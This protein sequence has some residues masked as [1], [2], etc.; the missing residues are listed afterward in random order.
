MVEERTRAELR[1]WLSKR[2]PQ[3]WKWQLRPAT[4]T[5]GAGVD[6]VLRVTSPAG[7][8]SRFYVETK[9]LAFPAEVASR[10]STVPRR[11]L[12]FVAPRISPRS[13]QILEEAGVDWI[14]SE[15]GDARIVTEDI[16]IERTTEGASGRWRPEDERR[17]WVADVFSGA[18]V[19]IVR[20]LLIEPERSWKLADMAE[21]VGVTAAFVSRVFTTLERDAYLQKERAA[22]RLRDRDALLEAW[23][24]AP[25]PPEQRF[26]RA[27]VH[28]GILNE[29]ASQGED[30]GPV[31][32]ATFALTAEVAAEQ[33]APFASWN[34]IEMYVRRIEGWDERLRLQPVPR[35]GN[36]VLIVPSDPGVFDGAF[37]SQRLVL[38]S[39]PQ[40]YVDLKRRGGAAAE[41]AEFLK[42]RGELWPR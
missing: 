15:S 37:S 42:E 1:A 29:I 38:A 32:D 41:T 2:L 28:P 12:L 14:E 8:E 4:R 6:A 30:P 33:I 24:A 22:T 27:I 9:S 11:P 26:K 13:R 7:R 34:T 19:R 18:A 35:G 31:P 17:R 25:P 39:R 3:G 10:L 23:V 36:F 5:A 16:L 40:V 20:W 21:R